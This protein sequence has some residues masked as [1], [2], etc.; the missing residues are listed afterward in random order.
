MEDSKTSMVQRC[1]RSTQAV[2]LTKLLESF[3]PTER[4]PSS[5]KFKFNCK[6][7][8]ELC[9]HH[10]SNGFI[11]ISPYD[12]LSA[13]EV[14]LSDSL[15]SLSEK[16]I[17]FELLVNR[18]MQFITH[19]VSSYIQTDEEIKLIEDVVILSVS[20]CPYGNN[21]IGWGLCPSRPLPLKIFIVK[22]LWQH[23]K[24]NVLP[25]LACDGKIVKTMAHKFMLTDKDLLSSEDSEIL[26][27][28]CNAMGISSST[29]SNLSHILEKIEF[30]R[31][32][33]IK[34]LSPSI[35]RTVFK[36]EP[37]VNLCID[38]AMKITRDVVEI[39]NMERRILMNE[40][41]IYD[42]SGLSRE[43]N[44]IIERMT[45]EGAPW[46]NQEMYPT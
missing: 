36:F 42:E 26:T 40:M 10:F 44:I 9:Q 37:I 3:F 45:H 43:W 18:V 16:K 11:S 27:N 6:S 28:V 5:K 14:N 8:C 24:F 22:K 30:T 41:R 25:T 17:R 23:S 35:E 34:E 19:K 32:S 2:V 15:L 21:I 13:S 7:C 33:S 31:N 12:F 46:C 20:G 39:Q 4:T 29:A 1:L 38:S